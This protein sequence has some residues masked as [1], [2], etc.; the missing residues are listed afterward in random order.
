MRK[1][2]RGA[3]I[4]A[5]LLSLAGAASAQQQQETTDAQGRTIAIIG[6]DGSAIDQKLDAQGRVIV[7][8]HPDGTTI[9]YWYDADGVRH[10]VGEEHPE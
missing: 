4:V 3:W 5:V 7:E 9:R 6:A 10:E 1:C 2:R 8:R